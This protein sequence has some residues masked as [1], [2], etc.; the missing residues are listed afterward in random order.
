MNI[1]PAKYTFRH[2]KYGTFDMFTHKVKDDG[3]D[4]Y[5]TA[6][7]D[8]EYRLIGYAYADSTKR[9]R[10]RAAKGITEMYRTK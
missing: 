5:L 1:Y 10:V 7:Y 8:K 6:V 9:S 4:R 3:E 2:P